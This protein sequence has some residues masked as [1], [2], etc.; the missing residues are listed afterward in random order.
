M[1]RGSLEEL[2]ERQARRWEMRQRVSDPPSSLSCIALSRLPHSGAAELAESLAEKLDY[3]FFGIEIVDR[4]ARE[5]RIQHDLVAGLDEHVRSAIDRFV[6]DFFHRRT[7][8]ETDYLKR[9]VQ[10]VTT[11]GERGRTVILGRG[12]PFILPAERALRVLVV[13]PRDLRRERW[14]KEEGVS[15]EEALSRFDR[16]EEDRRHFLRHQFGVDPDDPVLYDLVVNT[17]SIH[18]EDAAALV[19]ECLKRRF[20]AGR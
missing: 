5:G 16:V 19:S 12:A 3:G 7:F 13:A 18:L 9:V 20:P 11:L 1:R 17:G 8:T 4:I 10:T 15:A 14:L 2:V 6:V